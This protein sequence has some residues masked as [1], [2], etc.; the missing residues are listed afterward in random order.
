MSRMVL[1]QKIEASAVKEKQS[2]RTYIHDKDFDIML[3]ESISTT[4]QL[5]KHSLDG[6]KKN[7]K[8]R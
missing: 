2:W 3:D 4:L 1:F 8:K 6:K 5:G 7:K